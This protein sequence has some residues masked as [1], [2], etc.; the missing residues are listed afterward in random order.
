MTE[1]KC[2]RSLCKHKRGPKGHYVRAALSLTD[3]S[4]PLIIL[5]AINL[6]GQHVIL[7]LQQLP[8]LDTVDFKG[9]E[10]LDP[11]LSAV[12]HETLEYGVILLASEP[13]MIH[14]SLR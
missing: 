13:K 6:S 3:I 9:L 10:K 5:V 8:P 2:M 14:E 1:K 11:H 12:F 7:P 4:Y